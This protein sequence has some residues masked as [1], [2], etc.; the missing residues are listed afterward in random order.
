MSREFQNALSNFTQEA[1][2]GGA[3]RHL[4]DLGYTVDQIYHTLDFPTSR[5]QIGK[6]IWKYFTENGTIRYDKPPENNGTGPHYIE[7]STYVVD[8]GKFGTTS[9]RRV[10]TK[11]EIPPTKY[12]P[13]DFGKQIYKDQKKFERS[14][15][16]LSPDDR[17]YILGLPWPLQTVYHKETERMKQIAGALQIEEYSDFN[18]KA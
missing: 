1:A 11:I 5:E 16:V 17:D 6:T 12:Y 13:C 2:N 14:L 4:A 10:I 7:K 15:A 8:H 3:I 9:L 18:R